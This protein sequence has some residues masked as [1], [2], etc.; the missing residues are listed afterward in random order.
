M[1]ET[2]KP[3]SGGWLRFLPLLVIVAGLGAA[4]ALGLHKQLSFE[5][6]RAQRETLT[7][8][9]AGQPVAAVAIF[10]GVYIAFT[11]LMI[12]GA[13]WITIAGGFLFDL[14][15]GAAATAVGATLGATLLF[16]VARTSLGEPLRRRAGPFLKRLEAGFQESPF[17]YMLTLRFLPVV[18]FPVANIAPAVLGAKLPDYVITTALGILP[19][20]LAYT[21]IGSG[22]GAA[23]DSGEE[24]NIAGFAKQLLP[25][26]F[27]LAAVS[28][29]PAL[30]KRLRRKQPA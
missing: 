28:L 25:A 30:V 14:A 2:S 19:G 7:A 26:F 16:L 21:W 15:G 4:I 20:V 22:L 5:T 10:L 12:P 24:P 29:A 11:A 8:F 17:S 27:A 3:K 9:V 1:N 23:F 13:L 6:L 18:P